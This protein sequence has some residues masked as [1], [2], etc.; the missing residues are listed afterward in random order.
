MGK[1]FWGAVANTVMPSYHVFSGYPSGRP[2]FKNVYLGGRGTGDSNLTLDVECLPKK[3]K[4]SF[5][6]VSNHCDPSE[7]S[8]EPKISICKEL[9]WIV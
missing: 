7:I 6:K 9:K 1:I 3:S 2:Q 8:G 4:L 5:I